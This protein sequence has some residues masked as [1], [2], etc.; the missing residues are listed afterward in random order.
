MASHSSDSR[1]DLKNQ[2][3]KYFFNYDCILE[4]STNLNLKFLIPSSLKILYRQINSDYGQ[5][6]HTCNHGFSFIPC[7]LHEFSTKIMNLSMLELFV[8]KLL[9]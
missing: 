3:R 7:N 4:L 2:N 1:P 9:F 6:S 8:E 5:Q